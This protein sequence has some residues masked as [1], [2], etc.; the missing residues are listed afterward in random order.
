MGFYGGYIRV[1]WGY[2]AVNRGY[3]E[4]MDKT[5]E[6]TIVGYIGV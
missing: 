3:V 5:M 2:I 6:A 4:I 1:I